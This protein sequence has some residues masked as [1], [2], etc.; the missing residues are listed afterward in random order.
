MTRRDLNQINFSEFKYRTMNDPI[1]HYTMARLGTERALTNFINAVLSDKGEPWMIEN[2]SIKNPFDVRQYEGDKQIVV[3]I[4][5]EDSQKRAY[6]IEFQIVSHKCFVERCLYYWDRLFNSQIR[7]GA[8]FVNLN[9]VISIILTDFQL[10]DHLKALQTNIKTRVH[11]KFMLRESDMPEVVLTDRLQ[12][13]FIQMPSTLDAE[14]LAGVGPALAQWLTYFGF[15]LRTK[16][17]AMKEAISQNESIATVFGDY[18]KFQ[19]DP[20]LR[21]LAE[22]AELSRQFFETDRQMTRMEALKEGRVKDI[23][24]LLTKRFGSLPPAVAEALDKKIAEKA[25][26]AECDRLFDLA[27]DCASV[28]QFQRGL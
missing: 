11:S 12:M 4:H 16:E 25:D 6:D 5:A 18:V 20:V 1:V 9:P 8:P 22:D 7:E 24:R 28:E 14:S 23:K 19:E 26:E 27:M 15:P 17:E 3:D 13:H 21:K 2:I 10:T